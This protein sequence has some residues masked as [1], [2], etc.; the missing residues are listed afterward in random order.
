MALEI[1]HYGEEVLH[2]KGVP[3][4]LFDES[5]K[6]LFDQ[7]VETCIEAEG[8]GLAAQQIGKALMFCVVDL[9]GLEID[10]EYTLDGTKPPLE[11][12][13]PIGLCNPKINVIDSSKTVYEE[14]G[15]SF[16]DIR[17]EVERPDWIQCDY[18][19]I[20]GG[21]HTLRCNGLLGRCIQHEVDHLNGILFTDRMKKKVFK[22]IQSAV[23]E[24][25]AQTLQRNHS[26]T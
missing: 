16:P 5:L 26:Q 14:G 19:D 15:L 22:K 1:V 10:F 9:R 24:I 4:T 11:L 23:I 8:I 6:T 3:V 17:G 7:M 12:F 25:R 18:Q 20:H 2:Q 13:N 21:S